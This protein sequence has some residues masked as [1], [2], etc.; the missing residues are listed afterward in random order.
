MVSDGTGIK[1]GRTE[2]KCQQQRS[3]HQSRRRGRRGRR[4]LGFCALEK[5]KRLLSAGLSA[6]STPCRPARTHLPWSY[7]PPW[8]PPATSDRRPRS[9]TRLVSDP[10]GEP[11]PQKMMS[12]SHWST[13]AGLPGKP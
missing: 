4:G 8:L 7:P 2:P 3:K 1:G 11:G 5:E 9:Q 13:E 10:E 12:T 6:A